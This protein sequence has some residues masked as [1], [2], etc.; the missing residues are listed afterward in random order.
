M[1]LSVSKRLQPVILSCETRLNDNPVY[2]FIFDP[3]RVN[4]S[5]DCNYVSQACVCFKA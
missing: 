3:S 2:T 1:I 5:I 4:R